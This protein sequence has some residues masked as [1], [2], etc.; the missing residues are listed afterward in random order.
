MNSSWSTSI[1]GHNF[2]P[3]TAVARLQRET[4]MLICWSIADTAE[5]NVPRLRKSGEIGRDRLRIQASV[6]CVRVKTQ[7]GMRG[8]TT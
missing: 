8:E 3:D 1:V 4:S 6:E 2:S 5:T 7:R